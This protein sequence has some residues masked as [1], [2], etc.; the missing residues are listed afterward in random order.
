MSAL[1]HDGTAV[2]GRHLQ[3]VPAGGASGGHP[4]A[5]SLLWSLALIAV[6]APA[7]VRRYARG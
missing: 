6:F 2:P 7:A 1:V 4:V 5:G 3:K